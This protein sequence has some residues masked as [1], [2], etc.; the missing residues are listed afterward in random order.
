MA[1]VSIPLRFNLLFNLNSSRLEL[2]NF[3]YADI[4]RGTRDFNKAAR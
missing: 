1:G 4:A 3:I 2:I